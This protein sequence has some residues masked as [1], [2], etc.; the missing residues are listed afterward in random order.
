MLVRHILADGTTNFEMGFDVDGNGIVDIDDIFAV[1]DEIA[2]RIVNEIRLKLG[3]SQLI[4]QPEGLSQTENVDA[5]QLYLRGLSL[6]RLRGIDNLRRAAE[7]FEEAT[8]IDPEYARAYEKLAM[9]Y[10]LIPFYT[11][12]PRPPWLERGEEAARKAIRLEPELPGAHATLG[13]I[14]QA[15]GVAFTRTDAE[16]STALQLDPNHVTARQWYGEF[17]MMVGRSPEFLEAARW[18]LMEGAVDLEAFHGL[19]LSFVVVNIDIAYHDPDGR[20]LL[21]FYGRE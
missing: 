9:A 13:A 6:L 21:G 19:G 4:G 5:Y 14:Y 7:L 3:H 15:A 17:L 16:F 20:W 1:Q 2:R 10:M 18:E 11:D 12:E 8:Y